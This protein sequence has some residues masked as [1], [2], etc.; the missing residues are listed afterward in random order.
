MLTLEQLNRL[1]GIST[2][3]NKQTAPSA[4]PTQTAHNN[5]SEQNLGVD[6]NVLSQLDPKWTKLLEQTKDVDMSQYINANT[7]YDE[8]G[9][10]I[11]DFEQKDSN[12]L[13]NISE[14]GIPE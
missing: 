4:M 7:K 2:N 9:V 14:F 6:K 1:R 8:F 10:P 13:P 11:I 5:I 3:T 12:R